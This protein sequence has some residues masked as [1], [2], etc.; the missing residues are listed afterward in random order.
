MRGTL[1]DENHPL[2]GKFIEEVRSWISRSSRPDAVNYRPLFE[3]T[4]PVMLTQHLKESD[5]RLNNEP[6]RFEQG[7]PLVILG[8]RIDAVGEINLTVAEAKSFMRK[9]TD[10]AMV[11]LTEPTRP[12]G[13]APMYGAKAYDLL[14][15][16]KKD[17]SVDSVFEELRALMASKST[18]PELAKGARYRMQNAPR[19][20]A[21]PQNLDNL[22]EELAPTPQPAGY[23]DF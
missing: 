2:H 10:G 16:I 17:G 13:A 11:G 14:S 21:T 4:V 6:I 1:F 9:S 8:S 15:C 23:G 5:D 12:G 19:E 3:L 20:P 18:T 22:L 7:T